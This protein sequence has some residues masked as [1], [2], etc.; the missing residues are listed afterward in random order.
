MYNSKKEMELVEAKQA[1][2]DQN[3]SKALKIFKKYLETGKLIIII[4]LKEPMAM[5]YYGLYLSNGV[6]VKNEKEATK[7]FE[8]S[9]SLD[10][11]D[12]KFNNIKKSL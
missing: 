10:Y 2:D 4:I 11:G 9:A 3:H 7:Y 8:K 6:L 1:Y 12:G 5:Y